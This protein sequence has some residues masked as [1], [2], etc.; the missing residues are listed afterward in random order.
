MVTC[1]EI[2]DIVFGE[3]RRQEKTRSS[4]EHHHGTTLGE[5]TGEENIHE[6]VSE[7]SDAPSNTSTR[8]DT[9]H[10]TG[11]P[12]VSAAADDHVDGDLS[13]VEHETDGSTESRTRQAGQRRADQRE[14]VRKAARRGVVFGFVQDPAANALPETTRTKGGKRA[15][16]KDQHDVGD[17]AGPY[18][19]KCEAVMNG[20]VVEP[21]YAKGDW[22]IR[23][24]E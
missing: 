22:A 24:R 14:M 6:R 2:E 10:R 23:W 8:E 11:A 13:S 21:S 19:R 7:D 4:T 17:D 9:S 12:L 18:R 5:E 16:Q 15:R 20:A 3:S 1:D